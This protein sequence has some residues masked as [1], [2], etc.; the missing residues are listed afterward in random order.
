MLAAALMTDNAIAVHG[1]T[2]PPG[3]DG[4]VVGVMDEL[5]GG[6]GGETNWLGMPTDAA[7]HLAQRSR[8]LLRGQGVAWTKEFIDRFTT[9]G[10][11]LRRE[12]GGGQGPRMVAT[13][14]D[15]PPSDGD[16]GDLLDPPLLPPLANLADPVM[17]F[18]LSGIDVPA[19]DLLVC[20]RLRAAPLDHYPASLARR[21]KV[22]AR[23]S[24]AVADEGLRTF[25][26]IDQQH[27]DAVF[28]FRGVGPG[29]VDLGVEVEGDGPVTV[30]K[31]TAHSDGDAM[32]RE[33]EHGVVLA[34]PS[35]RQY[36]FDLAELLPGVAL[37]RLRGA[38]SQDP[39]TN[40]GEPVSDTVV[41]GP[42]DG[43]CLMK[44]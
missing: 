23:R 5:R 24:G 9:S 29:A 20:T 16:P 36:T 2:N 25:T 44:S 14:V 30:S 27:F 4:L 40:N 41:V 10:V 31:M 39:E 3:D 42:K 35:D 22:T 15:C 33:F 11:A 28:Y 19:W 18:G 43:L 38:S 17:P 32:F 26:W 37:R 1:K 12:V 8:D 34:N 7:L 13:C 6:V 21:V